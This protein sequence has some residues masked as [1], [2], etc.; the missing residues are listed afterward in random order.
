MKKFLLLTVALFFSISLFAQQS[1]VSGLITDEAGR[2][3]PFVSVH[4]KGT[5]RGTSAN[6]E[7]RYTLPLPTGE[8]ELLY[9]AIGFKQGSK[10]ITIKGAE[11]VNIQLK[12]ETYEL[13]NVTIRAGAEDPAYA[14]IRKA[15]KKRKGYLNEV[16]AFSCDVYIKGL[17]KLLDAPK[18]F[19]GR[20]INE[21]A[22]EAG[23]DSNRRGII[24]L[25]ESESKYSFKRPN[26][27]HEEM[28]S[29][30][31]SG[32]NRAF[33]FNRA[34]DFKVNFYENL[35]DWDGLSNRP[36]VSPIADNALF[37]YNYKYMGFTTE[38]GE[39][40]NKIKVIP[41][42]AHDPVFD[43]YI[44]IIDDSWRLHSVDLSMSKRSNIFLLDTLKINQQFLPVDKNAWM[45]S[46]VKFEF[47]GG[48]LGFKFGGYFIGIFKNYD[49]E[50]G[51]AKN[52]FN[53]VMRI[54]KGVNKKDSTYWQNSRPIP[55]TDEEITDYKKKDKLAARR[56]SK[57][58]LDSIDAKRN[59]FNIGKL[60]IGSGY[61]HYNRYDR[62]SY[63][64]NS[65]S[66]SLLFNTVEGFAIDYGAG[67]RKQIDSNTNRNLN[68][69]GKIRY[70]FAN[71][72]WHGSIYGNISNR[73]LSFNWAA[74]S[75][76]VDMNDRQ[77]ISPWW[78]T[79]HSLLFRQNFEKLYD[80][81]FANLGIN[82]RVIGTWTAG[83][84]A[85]YANR[86][87]LPNASN[88]S[89]FNPGNRQYTS[90]NPLQPNADVPLFAENQSFKVTL[91]TSYDFSNKYSTYP[92]GRR[93]EP[94]KYPRVDLNFTH[95]FSNVF[96]SDVDYSLVNA[97]ITKS[98][99]NLGMLGKTSFYI[100]AGKFL[101]AKSLTYVDYRHF[102]GN[103]IR[104]YTADIN[105]FMLLDYYT[106]ST[107]DQYL[108][109]HFEQNF[110]GFFLN[111]LPLIRKLKLQEIVDVNYLTTP[112]LHNYTEL[113]FGVQYLGFRV[114]FAK[115][116]NTGDN[117]SNALR[118]GVKL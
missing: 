82:T 34:S 65:L 98:N 107:P 40:I 29:S 94:S 111:K 74:G 30:K 118:I 73:E 28:I 66:Q 22:R 57:P 52:S 70:G 110:S 95:A 21:V 76:V 62:E 79:T 41:K 104:F 61:S 100:G 11:T 5:T 24:Y 72:K 18:R 48:F 35:L 8:Y 27:E 69:A 81:Q 67:F 99:M 16:K 89:I 46:S 10:T 43:G 26:E 115:S 32:N 78:N 36:F 4:I 47:T 54:T 6:S 63:H 114:M 23:L 9:K 108:E 60:I 55:L 103:E 20:D 88:Y 14:I 13:K 112:A 37:Y 86:K 12:T 84:N 38:N 96:G 25:S 113:G 71:Q 1:G 90:N 116:F 50:P 44:Y 87:W 102:S 83:I 97:D 49:I 109:G 106:Y 59:K 33:S 58:Y 101:S 51:F 45:P 15:I 19:L 85:E 75:D 3:V 56:E 68:L 42:R 39:T 7:G 92:N 117:L 80:K 64:F 105:K 2:P 31:V 93:Y 91:R 77:P 17:Q 53:E